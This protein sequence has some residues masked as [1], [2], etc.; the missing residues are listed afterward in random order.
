MFQPSD[1]KPNDVLAN[2]RT[3]LSY[4]RTSLSFIAFGF[5]IAR[6]SLVLREFSG[7]LH[8]KT[9]VNEGMASWFG[10]VM[11]IVGVLF[12]IAG[13]MRYALT[14]RALRRGETLALPVAWAI[15]GTAMLV[16][17]GAIVATQLFALR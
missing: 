16:G 2:E 12:G 9:S 3:F 8:L 7:V 5:V 11:A 14:D 6:F 13:A 10:V 4:V 17:I 15:V 1:I